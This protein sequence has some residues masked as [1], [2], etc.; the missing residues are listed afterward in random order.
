MTLN[1]RVIEAIMFDYGNTLIELSSKQVL[2]FNDAL[3]SLVISFFGSC[4]VD[5][6]TGIR[7]KQ[8]LKPYDNEEFIENDRVSLCIELIEKLYC[9]TPSSEQIEKMLDLK[10]SI[11]VEVINLPDFVIPLLNKLK[12]QYRIAFIS[13][14]PCRESILESLN[15]NSLTDF[16]ESIV[17]SGDIGR[18]KP[19]PSIFQKSIAELN[20]SAEKCLYVGDNWLADIQGAKR[21]GMQAIHTT[22][23]VSYENFKPFEGDYSPD[24]IITH[25]NELETLLLNK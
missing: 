18:V 7:K 23:Y 21:A 13:N 2:L 5:L 20:I 4:G 14:Y 6:F 8:I 1:K 16:F 12:Q 17:I 19:H 10:Q 25:L 22:Q 11:F 15:K 3:L 24:A 9:I